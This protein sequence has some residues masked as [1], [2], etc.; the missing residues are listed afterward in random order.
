MVMKIKIF[1]ILLG[2]F[3]G[4]VA[5]HRINPRNAQQM[6][7]S[8]STSYRA[9][10]RYSTHQQDVY[11][12]SRIQFY[13]KIKELAYLRYSVE[14]AWQNLQPLQESVKALPGR[15][16]E[17]TIAQIVRPFTIDQYAALG[18]KASFFTAFLPDQLRESAQISYKK[19]QRACQYYTTTFYECISLASEMANASSNR[20]G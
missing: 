18:L 11:S 1:F 4:V 8:S 19:Y 13:R 12:A 3:G 20:R 17:Y 14:S 6:V 16:Y 10:I 15:S 5:L 7:S 2:S 9:I